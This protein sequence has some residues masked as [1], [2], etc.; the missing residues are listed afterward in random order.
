MGQEGPGPVWC[1][2]DMSLLVF[3]RNCK[4]SSSSLSMASVDILYID[5]TRRW[6]SMTLDQRDSGTRQPI[7]TM[8]CGSSDGGGQCIFCS[9]SVRV[10]AGGRG[11][12]SSELEGLS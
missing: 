5:I 10:K 3:G 1:R 9:F 2:G 6:N 8:P 7:S 12:L 4:L 11:R